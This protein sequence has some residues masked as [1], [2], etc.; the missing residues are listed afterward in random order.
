MTS[1]ALTNLADRLREDSSLISDHVIDPPGEPVLGQIAASGPRCAGDRD[2]YALVIEAVREGYLLHYGEPR[3]LADLDRDLA[4]L[5]GDYLY[6]IGIERLAAIGDSSS[7]EE[8]SDL[9]SLSA[10]CRADGRVG[11]IDALWRVT[12]AAVGHG[13]G[14]R[15]RAAKE[16]VRSADPAASELLDRVAREKSAHVDQGLAVAS[17]RTAI[18]SRTVQDLQDRTRHG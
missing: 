11:L 3:V 15:Y 1:D 13:A 4:L 14:D 12:A 18:D 9:I 10:Q 16:A 6:A 7:V 8:I 17:S 5:A 2:G